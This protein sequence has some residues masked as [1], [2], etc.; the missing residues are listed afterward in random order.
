MFYCTSFLFYSCEIFAS[1]GLITIRRVSDSGFEQLQWKFGSKSISY[2]ESKNH[3][4]L[5]GNK[6]N[7]GSFF[8]PLYLISNAVKYKRA[9]TALVS[10]VT[11]NCDK[12]IMGCSKEIFLACYI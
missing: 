4:N 7:V 8:C 6:T 2:Q 12:E 3:M 1:N 10:H 5:Y 9:T 11:F